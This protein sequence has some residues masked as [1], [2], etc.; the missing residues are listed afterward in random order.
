MH[1]VAKAL[2]HHLFR[3]FDAADLGNPPDIV[4]PQ[5]EQH[6]VL[7][8]LLG[9]VAEFLLERVVLGQ[10]LAPGPGSGD[11]ADSNLLLAHP[12]QN[13]RWRRRC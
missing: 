12:H 4:A 11:R 1:D 13:F 2:D 9:V 10:R 3:D 8:Q 7:G 6:E 5:I